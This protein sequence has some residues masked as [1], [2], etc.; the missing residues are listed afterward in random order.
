LK[1]ASL[2]KTRWTDDETYKLETA[3]DEAIR[4]DALLKS[5][6]KLR[7]SKTI[8]RSWDAIKGRCSRDT[9]LASK[10]ARVTLS[11]SHHAAPGAGQ[12]AASAA[13]AAAA[14]PARSA[15]GM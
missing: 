5:E 9:T 2:S 13:A 8:G 3:L 10:L 12:A 1:G 14:A 7:I 11:R 4:K 6:D 15:T